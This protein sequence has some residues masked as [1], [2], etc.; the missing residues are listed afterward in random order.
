VSQSSEPKDEQALQFAIEYLSKEPL[1][2]TPEETKEDAEQTRERIANH[3]Y[4]AHLE[5]LAEG[6]S[7]WIREWA[8]D[9]IK[10]LNH[11]GQDRIL[12]E[13]IK[14][15]IENRDELPPELIDYFSREPMQ[16]PLKSKPGPDPMTRGVRNA[17][18]TG[19]VAELKY[20]FGLEVDRNKASRSK[21]TQSA[22]SIVAQALGHLKFATSEDS[23]V[24]IWHA[25]G[26]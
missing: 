1:N 11:Y 24:K 13:L 14:K 6:D 3:I 5:K 26:S 25:K 21:G 8:A 15:F 23:I 10:H 20:R 9:W 18:I 2:F 17:A 16:P 7:N 19:C 12:R 22:C 4:E